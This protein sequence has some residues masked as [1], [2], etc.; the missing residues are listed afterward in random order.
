MAAPLSPPGA[1]Q[2]HRS[3]VTVDAKAIGADEAAAAEARRE[4]TSAAACTEQLTG[5]EISATVRVLVYPASTD[6]P[7]LHGS[8]SKLVVFAAPGQGVLADDRNWKELWVTLPHELNH[9][10]TERLVKERW[11]A[12]GLG[13]L[14]GFTCSERR[15]PGRLVLEDALYPPQVALSGTRFGHWPGMGPLS[16]MRMKRLVRR[17]P[18]RAA[19]EGVQEAVRYRAALALMRRWM[20]AAAENGVKDPLRDLLRR[21]AA[22]GKPVHWR[23]MQRLCREQTGRSLRELFTVTTEERAAARD[24]AWDSLTAPNFPARIQALRIL[25]A[26]GLP[27]GADPADVIK[28]LGVEDIRDEDRPVLSRLFLARSVAEVLVKRRDPALLAAAYPHLVAVTGF[29]PPSGMPPLFWELWAARNR[30]QALR[31]LVTIVEDSPDLS[32]QTAADASLRRLTHKS[33]GWKATSAP[34]KRA[35]VAKR[36]QKVV[37]QVT[38]GE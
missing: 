38:A 11:L 24:R 20:A 19:M 31:R 29:D 16:F 18:Q 25:A 8:M 10:V 3:G 9:V 12:E 28:A 30:A 26:W 34:A 22:E 36:W 6:R 15:I 33:V 13:E 1:L 2:V 27:D 23:R 14:V 35:R 5:A 7:A 37:E 21:I 17:D 4:A 32:D